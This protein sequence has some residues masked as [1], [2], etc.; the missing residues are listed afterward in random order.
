MRTSVCVL[1]H[2]TGLYSTVQLDTCTVQYTCPCHHA[3]APM[4]HT[5]LWDM[6]Y[7]CCFI[8]PRTAACSLQLSTQPLLVGGS[9]T[10]RQGHDGDLQ[11]GWSCLG[12]SYLFSA[13][14][15]KS[16]QQA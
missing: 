11:K 9:N 14:I 16:V 2:C 13:V 15:S 6:L 4:L 10:G 5:Y 12:I 1:L 8:P 7:C 3:V